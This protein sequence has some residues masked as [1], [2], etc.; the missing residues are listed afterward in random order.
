MRTIRIY[1]S[2]LLAAGICMAAYSQAEN[3]GSIR[4]QGSVINGSTSLPADGISISVPGFSSAI[5]DSMGE[6]SIEVPYDES[7]LTLTGPG[8]QTREVLLRGKQEITINLNEKGYHSQ[9]EMAE[10]YY[11][12]KPKALTTQSIVS[13]HLAKDNWKNQATSAEQLIDNKIA[14]LRIMARSGTPGLGSNMFMRGF[15]S[16][17][18][19]NQPL[20]VLDGLI[21][22][23]AQY[24]TPIIR[25]FKN[26]PLNSINS[27]DIENITVVR[28]ASSIYGSRAGNGIIYIRTNHPTEMATKIDFSIYGGINYA[29]EQTPLMKSEDYRTYLAEI[30]QTSGIS[31]DSIASMP[32]MID[33]PAYPDYYRY[34]NETNWQDEVFQNSKNQNVNLKIMGGDDIALY[35]L[36]VGYQKHEGIIK[37]TD[38]S[39]YS[40]RFNSDINISKKL[41]LKTNL[42]FTFNQH[43]LKEDGET[44]NTNPLHTSLVKAPFLYTNVRSSTGAISPNLE[45][46]DIFGISNPT[47]LVNNMSA[48][49]NNYK[50]LGSVDIGYSF[51]DYFTLNNYLGINFDKSRD[52]VFI[53]YLGTASDTIESGVAGNAVAHKVERYFSIYNDFRANYVRTLGWKHHLNGLAGVRMGY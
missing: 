4:V 30:Y 38:Y 44:P 49:S 23:T 27:M 31:G 24:G 28:D 12:K 13:V 43:N 22:E 53:P 50:I 45:D 42:G 6:F 36:S 14:G 29:P 46:A 8:Y 52:N 19:S 9:D 47:A 20:I 41:I 37:N 40:F 51:S 35:A 39:K 33:D 3:P 5:S 32:F 21:Y 25:G 11:V 18:S 15:S 16:L 48:T 2:L 26:N 7:T 17:Y 34:H 1:F 10:L